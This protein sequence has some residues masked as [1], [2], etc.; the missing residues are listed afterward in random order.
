MTLT[1]S[2]QEKLTIAIQGTL[3]LL[4][5]GMSTINT[6]RTQTAYFKKLVHKD[7][8]ALSRAQIKEYK[9][10]KK[11]MQQNYRNRIQKAKAK[12]KKAPLITI[13]K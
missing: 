12:S 10:K 11:L 5:I 9:L 2:Q 3:S 8:K 6:V 1:P 7:A 13:R 4:I